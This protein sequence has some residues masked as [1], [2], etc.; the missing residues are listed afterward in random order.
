M[1]GIAEYHVPGRALNAAAAGQWVAEG[2]AAP[3][4]ALS[5]SNT[6]ILRPRKLQVLT[7]YSRELAEARDRN[8]RRRSRPLG[9][10]CRCTRRI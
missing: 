6:A 1:D 7:T 10:R 2:M 3:V 4:R 9:G 5:F 8:H